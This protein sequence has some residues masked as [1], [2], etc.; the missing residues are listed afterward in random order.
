MDQGEASRWK[1]SNINREDVDR[2]ESGLVYWKGIGKTDRY[3][4]AMCRLVNL[5]GL[6]TGPLSRQL[7]SNIP[8]PSALHPHPSAGPYRTE[9]TIAARKKAGETDVEEL[10]EDPWQI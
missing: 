3:Q 6:H 4:D 2:V 8:L 7:Y 9:A 5:S 10:E 1:R